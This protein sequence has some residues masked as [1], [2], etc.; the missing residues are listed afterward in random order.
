MLSM[1]M[2]RTC[3]VVT[4][5]KK[6]GSSPKDTGHSF[7]DYF[8]RAVNPLLV[9]QLLSEQ[10]MYVYEMVQTLLTRSGGHYELSLLYPVLYRL[11]SQGYVREGDK[12]ISDDNRVR[13]Y[14][15]LTAQGKT[16]FAK[17]AKEYDQM[18]ETVKLIRESNSKKQKK[19]S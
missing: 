1:A 16:H 9:M 18:V 12:K 11:V 14:Y 4:T 17:I 5:M 13:Q 10:S 7:E 19:T 2:Q 3:L 15:E 8:K 6:E